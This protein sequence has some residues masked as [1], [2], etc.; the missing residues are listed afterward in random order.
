MKRPTNIVSKRVELVI[1]WNRPSSLL[2][3]IG[4]QLEL[5][6][7]QNA[8]GIVRWFNRTLSSYQVSETV[9]GLLLGTIYEVRVR[10]QNAIGF[11]T[12][13]LPL[14]EKTFDSKCRSV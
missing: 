4:Y 1:V 13:S 11:G 9:G 10:A 7:N 14:S 6:P 8:S 3:L 12:W 5:R 2:P